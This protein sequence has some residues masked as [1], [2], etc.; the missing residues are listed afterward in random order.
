VTGSLELNP[1]SSR[2]D[3]AHR[4]LSAALGLSIVCFAINFLGVFTGVSLFFNKVRGG[5]RLSVMRVG[6]GQAGSLGFCV[7]VH[8]FGPGAAP[9]PPPPP[10]P[11]PPLLPPS[12]CPTSKPPSP[13]TPPHPLPVGIR[14]CQVNFLQILCH[15]IGFWL[16][17]WF[18][19]DLWH[20]T[21][22]W[23]VCVR[24]ALRRDAPHVPRMPGGR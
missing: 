9:S 11:P 20:Y 12:H 2:F 10:P 1:S 21:S 24:A 5:G 14:A 19:L 4:S 3:S 15:F 22:Y 8:V 7:H 18:I 17:V 16:V 6:M 13:P 23:C